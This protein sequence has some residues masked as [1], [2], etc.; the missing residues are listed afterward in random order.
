MTNEEARNLHE[1]D[2]VTCNTPGYY[3]HMTPGVI[4]T[5]YRMADYDEGFITVLVEE[6]PAAGRYY[7]VEARL[8][9]VICSIKEPLAEEVMSLMV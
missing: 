9:D 4:C 3:I 8:F 7:D 5:F 1:G 6:G 2:L